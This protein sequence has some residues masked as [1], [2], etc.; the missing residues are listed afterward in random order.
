MHTIPI[1]SPS[2]TTYY[3]LSTMPRHSFYTSLAFSSFSMYSIH[4]LYIYHVKTKTQSTR[5]KEGTFNPCTSSGK[6][7]SYPSPTWSCRYIHGKYSEILC[8]SSSLLVR[9]NANIQNGPTVPKAAG[10]PDYS[11]DVA[12]KTV[13]TAKVRPPP[14]LIKLTSRSK[15]EKQLLSLVVIPSPSHLSSPPSHSS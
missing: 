6:E 12:K 13:Q 3:T 10:I 15:V 9:H 8:K 11:K 14:P 4:L 7:G 2:L 1:S 5:Y